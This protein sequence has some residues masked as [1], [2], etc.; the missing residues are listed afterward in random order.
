M[1]SPSSQCKIPATRP[2]PGQLKR[3]LADGLDAELMRKESGPCTNE[4]HSGSATSA[5]SD[6][7]IVERQAA[8]MQFGSGLNISLC[9]VSTIE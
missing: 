3:R 1:V 7:M 8:A 6:L 5:P 9:K 4:S 2:S